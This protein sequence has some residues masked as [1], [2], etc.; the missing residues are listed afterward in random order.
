MLQETILH[1]LSY[2]VGKLSLIILIYL[3]LG[4]PKRQYETKCAVMFSKGCHV[5]RNWMCGLLS[6]VHLL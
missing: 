5:V 4:Q 6:T 3:V 2:R 1:A